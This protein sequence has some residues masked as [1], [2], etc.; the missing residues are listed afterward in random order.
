MVGQGSLQQGSLQADQRS[1]DESSANLHPD[2]FGQRNPKVHRQ[3]RDELRLPPSLVELR[4][5]RATLSAV[6]DRE[7]GRSSIPEQA[8]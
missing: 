1:R 3:E 4:R 7:G 2:W 8:L 6:I 5:I